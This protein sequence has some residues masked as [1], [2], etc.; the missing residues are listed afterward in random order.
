[1]IATTETETRRRLDLD[2]AFGFITFDLECDRPTVRLLAP[3]MPEARRL[4]LW[5][6]QPAVRERLIRSIEE[7][8]DELMGLTE[9]GR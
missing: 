8:L 6:S 3:N 5:L 9:E 1:M 2:R 7:Q 4:E